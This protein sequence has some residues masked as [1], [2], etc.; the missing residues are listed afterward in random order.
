[1]VDWSGRSRYAD[2]SL[3]NLVASALLEEAAA[4]PR[5]TAIGSV[6]SLGLLS[7]MNN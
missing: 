3:A 7:V 1:M 5:L 4:I 2:S 6:F